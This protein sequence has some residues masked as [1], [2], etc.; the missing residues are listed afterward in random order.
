M[1]KFRVL[2][3]TCCLPL[4]VLAFGIS[5]F[6]QSNKGTIVGSVKDPNDALVTGAKVTATNTATGEVRESASSDEG[7]Y[8]IPNLEP[9]I[10]LVVAEASGFQ[11]VNV[12]NVQLETNARL[13]LDLKF[14]TV[15][16]GAG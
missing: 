14:T 8:T 5:A 9:G 15:A 10:Y 1:K 6:A 7:I 13:P 11:T 16:G 4:V 2:V 3:Q 12:E